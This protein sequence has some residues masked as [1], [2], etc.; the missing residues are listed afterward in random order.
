MRISTT[1]GATSWRSRIEV[2]LAAFLYLAAIGSS[3]LEAQLRVRPVTLSGLPASE[4]RHLLRSA[5]GGAA[6]VVQLEEGRAYLVDEWGEATLATEF[7]E[8]APSISGALEAAVG[9]DGKT[10]LFLFGVDRLRLFEDG[11]EIE[12]DAP[13]AF[14]SGIGFTRDRP[15]VSLANAI[16]DRGFRPTEP[17]PLVVQLNT[18]NEWEEMVGRTDVD[19]AREL[20][21]RERANPFNQKTWLVGDRGG[22]LLMALQRLY[23]IREYEPGGALRWREVIGPQVINREPLSAET[24]ESLEVE[25]EN[26]DGSPKVPVARILALAWGPEGEA[27]VLTRGGG[28]YVLHRHIGGRDTVERISLEDLAAES[29]VDMVATYSGL[30]FASKSGSLRIGFVDWQSLREAKWQT[31]AAAY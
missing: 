2:A 26:L 13:P 8:K 21:R 24:L 18:K 4:G 27:L 15:T 29:P 6:Y 7:S 10:W 19:Y 14:V 9:D 1:Y 30:M 12:I 28:G 17:P 5:P 23:E 20:N 25:T 11:T 22:G 31:L 3:S 16:R